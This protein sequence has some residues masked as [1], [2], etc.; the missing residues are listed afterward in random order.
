MPKV[1]RRK[2]DIV[3]DPVQRVLFRRILLYSILYFGLSVAVGI[4]LHIFSNPMQA[5]MSSWTVLLKNQLESLI[6]AAVLLPIFLSDMAR[7]SVRF[8]APVIR[9]H[10]AVRAAVRGDEVEPLK[11][12]EKDYWQ[13]LAEDFNQLMDERVVNRQ[14]G[15]T[16]LTEAAANDC[17][18]SLSA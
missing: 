5:F 15:D 14:V 18:E 10:G 4:V 11:I 8:V 7:L 13:N 12:R 16:A 2:S 9:L 3:A 17:S 6:A 1:S